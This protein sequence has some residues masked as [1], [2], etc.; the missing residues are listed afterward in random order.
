[1]PDAGDLSA[2]KA[3]CVYLSKW[4]G[5]TGEYQYIRAVGAY[6]CHIFTMRI[7]GFYSSRGLFWSIDQNWPLCSCTWSPT[8]VASGEEQGGELMLSSKSGR[9]L[10]EG[11]HSLVLIFS[12]RWIEWSRDSCGSRR[13]RGGRWGLSTAQMS[14]Q[15]FAVT[16]L[17][18]L[19]EWPVQTE[20]L[21]CLCAIRSLCNTLGWL[22][23]ATTQPP[24][25]YSC[26]C[27]E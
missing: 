8:T 19:L 21:L 26:L 27:A 11:N 24:I 14:M 17:P 10:L 9:R 13:S 4:F 16:L 22:S 15:M 1:M 23:M 7:L 18:P 6:L 12:V 25:C 5:T 3:I 20:Q 2:Y